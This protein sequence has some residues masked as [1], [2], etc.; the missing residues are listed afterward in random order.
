MAFPE[1]IWKE[2]REAAVTILSDLEQGRTGRIPI[3]TFGFSHLSGEEIEF[4]YIASTEMA[5][6]RRVN[7]KK[8]GN[9]WSGYNKVTYYQLKRILT[10]AASER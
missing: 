3:N 10:E 9:A 5:S 6:F 1:V 4:A 2:S 8:R 7:L